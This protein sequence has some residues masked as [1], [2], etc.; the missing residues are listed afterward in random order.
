MN[1]Q[2]RTDYE[3]NKIKPKRH[4]AL[5]PNILVHVIFIIVILKENV[6][7]VKHSLTIFRVLKDKL[8]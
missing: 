3:K 5:K 6:K 4:M 1:A 8:W 2:H 7:V